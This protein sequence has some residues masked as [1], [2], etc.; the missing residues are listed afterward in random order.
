MMRN[1]H[2]E[3]LLGRRVRD[4]NGESVGH[5]EELRATWHGRQCLIDEYDLGPAALLERLGISAARLIGW[6]LTRKPLRVPWRQLDLS[7][8]DHPKLRCTV[9]ELKKMQ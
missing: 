4:V 9:D 6:P 3:T 2:V 7:D 8:P 1:V 5:I